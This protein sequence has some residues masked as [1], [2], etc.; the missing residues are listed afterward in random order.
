MPGDNDVPSNKFQLTSYADLQRRETPLV[1]RPPGRT[2]AQ[3]D[4][5]QFRRR[6]STGH[7]Q[8]P[9]YQ[10]LRRFDPRVIACDHFGYC[11]VAFA[12]R[13]LLRP[14]IAE[15]AT[16]GAAE[17]RPATKGNRRPRYT[18]PYL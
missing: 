14:T 6:A 8:I 17:A 7:P 12:T 9:R 4:P 5:G 1:L 16:L 2:R 18:A 13:S 3:T 15:T 11:D 10:R